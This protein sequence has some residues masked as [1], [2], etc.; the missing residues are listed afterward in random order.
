MST[1]PTS[2]ASSVFAELLRE[3]Q[4]ETLQR[5]AELD[6]TLRQRA[7][8]VVQATLPSLTGLEEQFAAYKAAKEREL[9]LLRQHA[10]SLDS[11]VS[12]LG[13]TLQTARRRNTTAKKSS[14]ELKERLGD[15]N[16]A[17]KQQSKVPSKGT[18]LAKVATTA[19]LFTFTK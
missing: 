19:A 4:R 7:Q 12:S 5:K 10:D 16:Q 1:R 6:E 17:L 14:K 8:N 13:S 2:H 11:A 9:T 18:T 15:L 3:S